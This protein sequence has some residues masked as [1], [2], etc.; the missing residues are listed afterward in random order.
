MDTNDLTFVKN[1]LEAIRPTDWD[2]VAEKSGVPLGTLRKVAY[3]EVTDP[4]F[5]TVKKLADY[6]R[7][8][9]ADQPVIEGKPIDGATVRKPR[10]AVA[11]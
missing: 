10:K 2:V 6:F 5:W 1:A 7:S 11:A 3:G 9:S 8:E 4:R